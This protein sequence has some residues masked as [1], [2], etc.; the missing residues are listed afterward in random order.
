MSLE[1]CG[2]RNVVV[3]DNDDTSAWEEINIKKDAASDDRDIIV[4]SSNIA[5]ISTIIVYAFIV[6]SRNHRFL[7]I[8]TTSKNLVFF[9]VLA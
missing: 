1:F 7:A 4:V 2:G 6:Y 9:I 3:D 8:S 5:N